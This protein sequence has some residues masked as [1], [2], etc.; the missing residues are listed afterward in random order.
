MYIYQ[1]NIN[2]LRKE[3]FLLKQVLSIISWIGIFTIFLRSSLILV[4]SNV[5]YS[6]HFYNIINVISIF[7]QIDYRDHRYHDKWTN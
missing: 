5:I 3:Y 7:L 1:V 2:L 4:I 6:L